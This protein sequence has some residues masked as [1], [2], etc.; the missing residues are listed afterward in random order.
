G[1]LVEGAVAVAAGPE[2]GLGQSREALAGHDVDDE[3]QVDTPAADDR[4]RL[5]HRPA[6]GVLPG[7]G[8]DD[9]GQ[10]GEETGDEGAGDELGDP[11]A[12]GGRA[13]AGSAVEALDELDRRRSEKWAEEA[14]DEPGAE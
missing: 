1:E 4:E 8:L 2:V 12:A 5:E 7:Q 13:A 3:G 14:G 11:P 10:R 9:P 6:P